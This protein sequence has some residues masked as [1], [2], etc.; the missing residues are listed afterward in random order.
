MRVGSRLRWPARSE[1]LLQTKHCRI[2]R[3]ALPAIALRAPRCRT[4][5]YWLSSSPSGQLDALP[6]SGVRLH[7]LFGARQLLRLKL[8]PGYG[9]V[10]TVAREQ[11]GG[12]G[13]GT[14]LL[15]DDLRVRIW[16]FRLEAGKRCPF[17]THST[18]YCFTNISSNLTQALD[19]SG[20]CVGEPAWQKRGRTVF[21]PRQHL[22]SHGVR[23]V[24]NSTFLQFIVE[25]KR[26]DS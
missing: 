14:R 7:W 23:N 1:L 26:L 22:G 2:E 13:V 24:G 6:R 8:T 5:E 10:S 16:E 4:P 17:H 21:V 12:A 19:A 11:K 15:I 3:F 20:E 18:P 9:N 25:F